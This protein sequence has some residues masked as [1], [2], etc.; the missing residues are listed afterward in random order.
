MCK[1]VEDPAVVVPELPRWE[2]LVK[3]ACEKDCGEGNEDNATN[4]RSE[5]VDEDNRRQVPR[6]PRQSSALGQPSGIL[7]WWLEDEDA[8]VRST[9][10]ER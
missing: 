8:V 10:H 3:S 9:A 6:R 4:R 5:G 2:P 1:V 7:L